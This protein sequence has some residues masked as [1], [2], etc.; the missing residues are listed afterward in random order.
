MRAQSV[1]RIRP[2][3]VISR[4]GARDNGAELRRL[5]PRG[6]RR[7]EMVQLDP[8]IHERTRLAILTTLFTAPA[9]CCVFSDLRDSLALTDGNLMAHLRA[10]ETGGLVER[11]KEGAGR[12]SSTTL[13]LSAHGRKAFRAYLN[14]LEAL[15]RGTLG[16]KPGEARP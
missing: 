13:Q 2:H 9:G 6:P 1:L 5:A 3:G 7:G 4:N 15:V 16:R 12:A 11:T 10:L 8:L 14:Q